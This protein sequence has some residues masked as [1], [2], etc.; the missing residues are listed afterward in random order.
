MKTSQARDII[1]S[2][3]LQVLLGELRDECKNFLDLF[4]RLH[5]GGLSKKQVEEVLGE[6]AGSVAHLHVHAGGLEELIEGELEK[7]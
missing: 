7:L 2:K 6:M 5:A 1:I 3:T 4:S